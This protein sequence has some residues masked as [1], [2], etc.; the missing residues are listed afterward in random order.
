MSFKAMQKSITPAACSVELVVMNCVHLFSRYLHQ[1]GCCEIMTILFGQLNH[2]LRTC[3]RA[4]S[5]TQSLIW[6]QQGCKGR[7]GGF[8][9]YPRCDWDHCAANQ[10]RLVGNVQIISTRQLGMAGKPDLD[11]GEKQAEQNRNEEESS[12]RNYDQTHLDHPFHRCDA[13][14]AWMMNHWSRILSTVGLMASLIV[15]P[16]ADPVIQNHS[17]NGWR[18]RPLL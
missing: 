14:W 6:F 16:R 4:H 3:G 7:Q 11:S 15:M 2:V 5:I 13:T 12:Y 17:L 18:S 10:A 1:S 8:R 9:H